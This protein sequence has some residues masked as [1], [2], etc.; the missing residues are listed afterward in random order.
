MLLC[1]TRDLRPGMTVGV[2]VF[3]SGPFPGEFLAA[4]TVLDDG[5]I[6]EAQRTGVR[7]AWVV[8]PATSDL[9]EAPLAGLNATVQQMA[10][11]LHE[12]FAASSAQR[13][14]ATEA[15]EARSDIVSLVCDIMPQRRFIRPI[16]RSMDPKYRVFE[17]SLNVATLSLFI[18]IELEAYIVRERPR[19]SPA[20]ARDM[21]SLVFGAVFHDAGK[22]ALSEQVQAHHSVYE[23]IRA[24]IAPPDYQRHTSLGYDLLRDTGIA[25]SARQVTLNHHQ[26]FN[27]SGWPNMAPLT[28]GRHRGPQ[29]GR[30]IHI[31]NRI[32]AVADALD[33][34]MVDEAG[35]PRPAIAAMRDLS[36][37]R[38][39][40]WFDPI[41]RE[42][43]LRRLP[44]FPIGS[45]VRTSDGRY[46]AV[47]RRNSLQPCRPTVRMLDMDCRHWDIHQ[48]IDQCEVVD[49]AYRHDLHV[50]R[51]AG[52]HVEHYL[53][54]LAQPKPHS[55][56][57]EA[58][59]STSTLTLAEAG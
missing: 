44:V 45:L 38:L 7:E 49:L 35:N 30:E 32:V 46:G 10:R 3:R 43:A 52:E 15:L 6:A 42:V 25:A 37:E 29:R 33:A 11:R 5:L 14:T 31:F 51:C 27:G 4:G 34:L 53:F 39:E 13:M 28:N 22:L 1:G 20:E 2:P 18:G 21:V 56:A 50:V 55:G 41:V 23:I 48:T 24:S 19:L 40:P 57:I 26:R 47:V 36:D 8:H 58:D 9:D 17:H 54:D 16:A 12:Q 59:G